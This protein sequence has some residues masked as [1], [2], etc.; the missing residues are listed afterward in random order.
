MRVTNGE[1]YGGKEAI[2][3]ILQMTLPV[4]ASYQIARLTA[5]MNEQVMV[6]DQ[7]RDGLIRT[8]GTEKKGQVTIE[9]G[10]DN[11]AKFIVELNELFSKE[12]D[13]DVETV[14]LPTTIVEKCE[15][16]ESVIEKPLQIEPIV[17]LSL[18]KFI[19]IE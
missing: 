2:G 17:L 8:Y 14:K 6:I 11:Y 15:K 10:T 7:V 12:V 19:E 5:K 1:I 9:K 3:K 4:R 13:M 18:E 16:C